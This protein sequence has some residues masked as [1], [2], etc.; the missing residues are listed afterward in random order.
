[1]FFPLPKLQNYVVLWFIFF[2]K[3]KI[4]RNREEVWLWI[5]EKIIDL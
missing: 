4:E 2:N 5:I 3:K 1:M